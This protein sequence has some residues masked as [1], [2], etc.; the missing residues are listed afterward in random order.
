[1]AMYIAAMA[2]GII[3][4]KHNAISGTEGDVFAIDPRRRSESEEKLTCV[5]VWT[6]AFAVMRLHMGTICMFTYLRLGVCLRVCYQ[7]T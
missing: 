6:Y 1:M 4:T 3:F 2:Q 5:G 7:V